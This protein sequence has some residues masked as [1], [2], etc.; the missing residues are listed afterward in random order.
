MMRTGLHK[1]QVLES[2]TKFLYHTLLPFRLRPQCKTASRMESTSSAGK[3][4]C[5]ARSAALLGEQA[6]FVALKKRGDISIKGKGVMTTFWVVGEDDED[7][8]KMEEQGPTL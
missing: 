2:L 5:S 8:N 6:P 7:E 4:Q 1:Y 3:V